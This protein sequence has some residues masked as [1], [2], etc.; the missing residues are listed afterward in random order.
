MGSMWLGT[1][2]FLSLT[3]CQADLSSSPGLLLPNCDSQPL[4]I[5]WGCGKGDG[6]V[7]KC[8]APTDR[9]A[10]MRKARLASSRDEQ[11]GLPPLDGCKEPSFQATKLNSEGW[12]R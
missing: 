7:I 12:M 11:P 2:S 1:S 3:Q 10:L 4:F 5:S 8:Q 6:D 9:R